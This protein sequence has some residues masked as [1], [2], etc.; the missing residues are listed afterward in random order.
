MR[1]HKQVRSRPLAEGFIASIGAAAAAR[2]GHPWIYREQL[3]GPIAS[4]PP[5]KVGRIVDPEGAVVGSA[6]LDPSSPIAARLWTHGEETIDRALIRAR[7][8]R[9]IAV[10]AG[11]FDGSTTAYRCVHGEGDR[12][13]GIV[14]DRYGDVA[15]LR[16]DGEAIAAWTDT[17]AD[18][19]HA[20]LSVRSL[21]LRSTEKGA[22]VK[23][24][25]LRGDDPPDRITVSEHGV[26]FVV[27]LAHGQKTGAFL[28]QRDNRRR[29]GQLARGRR[30]L[31][32]FSYAGGFS[33]HAAVGGAEHCTS[34]DVAAGAHAT[35]QASFRAA[36]IDPNAH[37]FVT[38]DVFGFLERAAARNERWDLVISDPPNMAPSAA[39]KPRAIAAYRK[40][41]ALCA[42]VLAPGGVFCAASCSSHVSLDDFLGTLADDA[43]G[44]GDLRV[45]EIAGAG[46]DH[47]VLP[48]FPEGRYLEM[49]VLA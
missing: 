2:R 37:S 12:A 24:R 10:R 28:D 19:L 27:D 45:I 32:L 34:V 33:L 6:L 11:M 31:N 22:T 46:A 39:T 35:A 4:A 40:L 49:C 25:K 21:C 18:E 5:G 8:E 1:S 47:P 17:I 42:K 44:R 16:L 23:L 38:A 3:R 14:V 13:P 30:V 48:G 43:L 29:I 9:A 36:G 26:P 41:H 15:I 20:A 7:I